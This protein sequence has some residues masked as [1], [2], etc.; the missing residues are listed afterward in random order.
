[1]TTA[2][3]RVRCCGHNHEI[4]LDERGRLHR[5]CDSEPCKLAFATARAL[6][7]GDTTW[8][9]T[10]G[11]GKRWR[12]RRDEA[13]R[14]RLARYVIPEPIT[15]V[16]HRFATHASADVLAVVGQTTYRTGVDDWHD[17]PAHVAVF[18]RVGCTPCVL[19]VADTI[20]RGK[21]PW[22]TQ[23]LQLTVH[24]DPVLWAR[25]VK[26][27][28]GGLVH[29]GLVHKGDNKRSAVA[30]IDNAPNGRMTRPGDL[31][32]LAG[33]QGRG[34]SV[35]TLPALVRQGESGEWHVVRWLRWDMLSNGAVDMV[36]RGLSATREIDS[37]RLTLL[38]TRF[39][40]AWAVVRKAK[41]DEQCAPYRMNVLAR[42]GL[43]AKLAQMPTRDELFDAHARANLAL[44]TFALTPLG[45][46][47][48]CTGICYT[49][50]QQDD[51]HAKRLVD[52][53]GKQLDERDGLTKHL[54][55][56]DQTTA[57]QRQHLLLLG[58]TEDEING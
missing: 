12:L 8:T 11:W 48:G 42:N 7:M 35:E 32:V 9:S 51:C 2:T 16:R 4:T 58:F 45:E 10:S 41:A 47:A 1:M 53:A 54:R 33:K 18:S 50:A 25:L 19:G 27:I 28:P 22:R 6:L 17:M 57:Q 26:R 29:E 5:T 40:P 46:T 21:K 23:Y 38:A 49:C 52:A 15:D 20:W 14:K 39:R 44:S 55:E 37:L 34:L 30:I 43:E 24:V 13:K 3:H 31:V 36:G 56:M